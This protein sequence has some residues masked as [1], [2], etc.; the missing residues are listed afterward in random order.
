MDGSITTITQ[1][2]LAL[3]ADAEADRMPNDPTQLEIRQAMLAI[4]LS[5]RSQAKHL[6]RQLARWRW[7]APH[8]PT[9]L[10]RL[11]LSSHS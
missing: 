5:R 8:C 2:Q 7:Q 9:E 6:R 1:Q 10:S 3:D 4:H 11:M